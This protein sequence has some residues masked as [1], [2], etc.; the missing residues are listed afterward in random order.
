MARTRG[1]RFGVSW[2]AAPLS[3]RGP[4]MRKKMVRTPVARK[5]TPRDAAERSASAVLH[6]RT[7]PGTFTTNEPP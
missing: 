6:P 5:A 2:L 1:W 7:P 4:W 3:R